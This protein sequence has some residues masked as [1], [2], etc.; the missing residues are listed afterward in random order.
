MREFDRDIRPDMEKHYTIRTGP[1]STAIA[2]LSMGGAQTL[3]SR[4]VL[5]L[6]DF[7]Y[8]GVFSSGVRAGGAGAVD[9]WGTQYAAQLDGQDRERQDVAPR[10]SSSARRMLE[11]NLT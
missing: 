7:G 1:K 5:H 11:W 9:A 10:S 8:I 4:Q 2:G 3:E 6:K